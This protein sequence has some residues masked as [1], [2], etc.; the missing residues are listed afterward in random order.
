[1]KKLLSLALSAMFLLM[2][3]AGCGAS[4]NTVSGSTNALEDE[5]APLE[6]LR[7]LSQY[8]NFD[9]NS[10]ADEAGLPGQVLQEVTG[11]KINYSMLPGESSDEKLYMEVAGNAQY[12]LMKL[13][14]AQ[15]NTL[16]S[17]G[18]LLDMRPYL[19]KYA[20]DLMKQ[21]V[22]GDEFWATV[23]GPNGE[24]YGVPQ[25]NDSN[26][27]T[28]CL[29]YR[30]DILEEHNLPVPKTTEEFASVTKALAEQG[31]QSPLVT[32]YPVTE[33]IAGAFGL[34][35]DWNDENG[36]LI[37]KGA[38]DSLQ[39]YADYM[40][41]IYKDGALG[42]EKSGSVSNKD[43][44]PR[45]VNGDA[46]FFMASWWNSTVI[47]NDMTKAGI[48]NAEDKIGW[49]P[50]LVGPDGKKG[51][52]RE[53]GVSYVASIPKYMEKSAPA[54]CKFLNEASKE[55]NVL[56]YALGKEGETY[57]VEDG[58]YVPGGSNPRSNKTRPDW[59]VIGIPD[60]LWANIWPATLYNLPEQYRA[61]QT[62]QNG[63]EEF[64]VYEQINLAPALEK[65]GKSKQVLNVGVDEE[66]ML[67]INGDTANLDGLKAKMQGE[68]IAAIT[69]EINDWYKTT[70]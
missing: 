65:W 37:F 26:H 4:T 11:Q 24:I 25:K 8:D 69:A 52:F 32:V 33:G 68:D 21:G 1:M 60:E 67:Y 56:E 47:I 30:K 64:G 57:T 28:Y 43:V 39:Q 66:L 42:Q 15:Y 45:F 70:K 46:A 40:R 22:I 23:T 9:P 12:D 55:A 48:E 38:S 17:Q 51:V 3:L 5:V 18:A 63:A 14:K 61:W 29:A 19:E 41:Q 44:F 16:S 6:E 58:M 54:V 31:I 35:N 59:Y 27:I 2:A 20:P 7:L 50:S 10:P 62:I 49:I 13:R 34:A 36:E 53:K